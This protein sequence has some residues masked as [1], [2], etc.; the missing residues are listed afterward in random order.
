MGARPV[1]GTYTVT[2]TAA[3]RGFTITTDVD[4]TA[5]TDGRHG[6][7][8]K[9]WIAGWGEWCGTRRDMTATVAELKAAGL[10]AA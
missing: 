7:V 3:P 2:V 9:T 8:A 1:T 5:E 4:V 6:R 10:T